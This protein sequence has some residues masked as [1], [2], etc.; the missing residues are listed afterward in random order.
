[1]MKLFEVLKQKNL[2]QAG[3]G[4]AA[5]RLKNIKEEAEKIKKQLADKFKQI[6]GSISTSVLV[7]LL[8]LFSL[9]V[10]FHLK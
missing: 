2:S 4:D 1:M 8:I 7:H 6:Q 9:T 5:E 10:C 3:Q